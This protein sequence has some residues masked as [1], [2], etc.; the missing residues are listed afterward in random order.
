MKTVGVINLN[1]T[2]TGSSNENAV[3]P[4]SVFQK[5]HKFYDKRPI[6]CIL[7]INCPG[8]SAPASEEI[9]NIIK[10]TID[11]LPIV[12]SIGDMACSGGYMVASVGKT[13]ICNP[14]SMIG[15]IGVILQLKNLSVLADKLGVKINYLIKGKYKDI[16]NPF[17]DVTEDEQKHFDL[18]MDQTY[19][20]FR[21]IISKNRN[22]PMEKLDEIADGRFFIGQTALE[23]GL[24]DKL[25]TMCDAMDEM[26]KILEID[27]NDINFKQIDNEYS[28]FN[29]RRWIGVATESLVSSIENRFMNSISLK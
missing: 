10:Q 3:S 9:M 18:M 21:S 20:N 2:I 6:G 4:L 8:G 23:L 26:A 17:R 14:S 19:Q 25:G 12:V 28:I 15:S 5:I 1:G 13:L 16:G 24:V 27:V 11:E 29:P 22:I 7:R